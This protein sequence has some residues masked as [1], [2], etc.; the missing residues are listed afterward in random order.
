VEQGSF[1]EDLFYRIHVIHLKIPPLRERKEDIPWFANRFL[2]DFCA[3]HGAR[4]PLSPV[5]QR[6]LLQHPWPGNLR[7]LKHAIE[8]ACILSHGATLDP[9]RLF[10]EQD[11]AMIENASFAA[12]LGQYLE[13]CER[14]HIAQTLE[15]HQGHIGKTAASLG[16]SRKNL[17][18]KLNKLGIAR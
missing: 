5:M 13:T 7:E 3:V 11:P 15:K 8:R 2:A 1:R 4:G 9:S 10:G 16:I 14:T 17:W 6:M 18:E 12:N